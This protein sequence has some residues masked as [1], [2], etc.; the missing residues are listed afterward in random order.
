MYKSIVWLVCATLIA[1]LFG[2]CSSAPGES[3]TLTIY[4]ARKEELMKPLVDAFEA[5]TG[6]DVTL[7]SGKPA[8]LAV[9]IQQEKSKPLGDIFFTTDAGG[10]ENLRQLGLLEPYNSPNAAGV[11]AEFKAPDGSW[12]GVI[13]R[14]RNIIYNTELVEPAD[15]PDSIYDLTD[16]KYKNKVAIASIEEGSVRL[17]LA[18]L[19]LEKGKDAAVKYI[20]DLKANGAI[21]L[22][23][24]ED[25]ARAVGS[26]EIPIGITN[27]Y[28]YVFQKRDNKPVA[29][30]YPD[31]GPHEQGTLVIPLAVSIIK[32]ARN[33]D[34]AKQF[35]DFALSPEGQGTLTKQ[36]SEF[37]L[38][39][40]VGLGEAQAEGVKPI[41][42]IKRPAVDFGKLADA[43][44][45]MTEEDL[46]TNELTAG[47]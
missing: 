16:P 22:A 43:E 28:Y 19:L 2:A 46:F 30:V 23:E 24:N 35:V 26:G 1:S 39:P 47:E 17:W 40:G 27:H 29:L 9:T 7:K 37:P 45:D 36:E 10:A 44:E 21:V 8:E 18:W 20:R 15:V 41:D 13:G 31:Q 5:K 6:I 14:S 4:S 38:S 32:G 33:M 25:V 34:A 11:P 42:A 12:T 3:Q